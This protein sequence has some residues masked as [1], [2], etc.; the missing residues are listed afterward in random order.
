MVRLLAFVL[1]L[2]LL[3]PISPAQAAY[4]RAINGHTFCLVEIQRSAKNY[5]EYRAVVSVDEAVR[6]VEV[7]NCRDR[8]LTRSDGTQVPF[9]QEPASGLVCRL[10]RG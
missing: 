4:C 1:S 10:Y 3:L 7:Y 2:L 8:F 6:P 5:W 9:S